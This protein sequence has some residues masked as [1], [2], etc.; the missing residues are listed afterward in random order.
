MAGSPAPGCHREEPAWQRDRGRA[1]QEHRKFTGFFSYAH[2]DADTDPGLVEAFTTALEQRV[3]AKLANA[4]FEIWR[5]AQGLRTGDKWHKKLEEE[6][7]KSDLLIVLFTPRWVESDF[8]RREYAIFEEVEAGRSVGEYIVPILARAI[9]K[10]EKH[11]NPDQKRVCARLRE[12]QYAHALAAEFLNLSKAT[13]HDAPEEISI[14]IDPPP[15]KSAIADLA[16]PPAENENYFSKV[17]TATADIKTSQLRAE[18]ILSLSA[19]GLHLT[20]EKGNA[21]LPR[22]QNKIKAIMD[23]AAAKITATNDRSNVSNG[24]LRRK[25]TVRERS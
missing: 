7:R 20:N 10:Q 5:D 6:V 16:F 25:L 4:R 15:G 12:R 8:C 22:M 17:A 18:L 13:L 14:C 9:E 1:M 23:V 21:L 19:E 3:N 24:L 2:H 11:F